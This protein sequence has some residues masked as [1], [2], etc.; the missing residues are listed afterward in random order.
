MIIKEDNLYKGTLKIIY[1]YKITVIIAKRECQGTFRI[2][3]FSHLSNIH[4]YFSH[5]NNSL[6]KGQF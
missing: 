1:I 6:N 5:L 2:H 3:T 4:T